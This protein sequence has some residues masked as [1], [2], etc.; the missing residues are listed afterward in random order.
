VRSIG[1]QGDGVADGPIFV[2]LTLPGERV[3]ARVEGERAELE[4]VLGA[5]PERVAP[6]CPHFGAC[7]GC[8]LQHWAHAPYLAWKT[9][10]IRI[11]LA[12]EGIETTF[13]APFAAAPASRRRLALHARRGER[14]TT[15]LGY[16]ARGSWRLVP[17][18]TCTIADPALVAALPALLYLTGTA[19]VFQ[20]CRIGRGAQPLQGGAIGIQ[21]MARKIK[22][23]GGEF[24]AQPFMHRPVGH[25]LQPQVFRR[26]IAAEHGDLAAFALA[27]RRL[28]PAQH[29]VGIFHHL[30]AVG[31]E[32]VECP[33]PR[34]ILESAL[35]DLPRVNAAGKI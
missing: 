16:K 8:A 25:R 24:L 23:H 35:V 3:L 5:S 30:A 31:I 32:A 27:L 28:R 15:E 12:R 1:A 7:G 9:D 11:A 21:R 22:A 26:T 4:S 10:Q 20:Q 6:P 13:A 33:G 18:E 19:A 14:G 34:Q 2:P 29:P 17:I